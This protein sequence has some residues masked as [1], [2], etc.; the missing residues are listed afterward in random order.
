[1]RQIEPAATRF[2][3]N[4]GRPRKS[5]A[6]LTVHDLSAPRTMPGAERR[7][8]LRSR[9]CLAAV[10]LTAAVLVLAAASLV[11]VRPAFAQDGTLL[12]GTL[13]V[14]AIAPVIFGCDNGSTTT[15]TR[16]TSALSDDDFT[17]N[18]VDYDPLPECLD[19][20][21]LPGGGRGDETAAFRRL[22]LP[23]EDRDQ[24]S[25]LQLRPDQPLARKL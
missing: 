2:F 4:A 3:I 14:N 12:T 13:N 9:P 16:C 21:P 25:A 24:R 8:F 5:E 1:M 18:G 6:G 23:V 7:R 11:L 19:L 17:V 22:R 10:R 15:Q 20:G